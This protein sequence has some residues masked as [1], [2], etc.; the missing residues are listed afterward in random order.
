M[1]NKVGLHGAREWHFCAIDN[2]GSFEWYKIKIPSDSSQE[3][4]TMSYVNPACFLQPIHSD[5]LRMA[6]D[7]EGRAC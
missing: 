1:S 3:S 4:H 2:A 5:F 7:P 6:A